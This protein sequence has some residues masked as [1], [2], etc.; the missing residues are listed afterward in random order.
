MKALSCT[1]AAAVM[2]VSALTGCGGDDPTAHPAVTA[3]TT[4]VA[5]DDW[6]TATVE[7]SQPDALAELNGSLFVRSDTGEVTRVDTTSAEVLN[8]ADVDTENDSRHFC[9]GLAA[10]ATSLWTCSAGPDGTD[11]VRLDPE[12]LEETARVGVDK[13]FDQLTLPVVDGRIWVLS[14]SGDRVTMVDAAT[15]ETQASPLGRRCFQ[16]AATA[17]RVYA[18]CMLTDEVLALDASTGEV[19]STTAVRHPVNL[20]VS[21]ERV[22]VSTADGLV[23]LTADLEPQETYPGLSA[24]QDGDLVATAE[25]VWI[26]QAGGFLFR[27]DPATGAVRQFAIDPVPSGGSLL[28]TGDSVWT[29]AYNDNVVYRIDPST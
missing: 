10:D 12:T 16:L 25:A 15:G 28:V 5:Q 27:L 23:S 9:T 19:V 7:I 1:A 13:L 29:S 14:G 2:A 18:T 20:S 17:S 22:W 21:G 8:S 24:G 11:L 6:L 26:R 4:S 3:T